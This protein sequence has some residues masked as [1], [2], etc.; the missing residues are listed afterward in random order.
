[1]NLIIQKNK[2]R[3]SVWFVSRH[4]LVVQHYIRQPDV[5]GG[6]PEL[7]DP[8]VLSRVPRQPII[9]PVLQ[10]TSQRSH[11]FVCELSL[12]QT[13]HNY[14]LVSGL[15]S[16]RDAE[17]QSKISWRTLE[18]FNW[19]IMEKWLTL[20]WVSQTFVVMICSLSFWKQRN[21]KVD[22]WNNCIKM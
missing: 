13:G 1:M 9:V 22:F 15:M 16:G 11:Y 4:S 20:T 10:I 5:S 14:T 12:G 18:S 17:D 2:R 3:G 21:N 7:V 6:D 8:L 19:E